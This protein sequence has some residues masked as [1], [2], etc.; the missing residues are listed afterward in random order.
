METIET[1]DY[2]SAY[3]LPNTMKQRRSFIRNLIDGYKFVLLMGFS[4]TGKT[5]FLE[6][7]EPPQ[8][9]WTQSKW[10]RDPIMD[11][12]FPNGKRIEKFHNYAQ[13]FEKNVIPKLLDQE[14]RQVVVENWARFPKSRAHFYHLADTYPTALFVFD[15]PDER[16]I[17]RCK[18][19]GKFDKEGKDLEMWLQQKLD[20]IT[21]PTFDEGW[22]D[23]VYIST[24]G[25]AGVEYFKERLV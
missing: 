5:T 19:S 24:F 23:I 13:Q 3:K 14:R 11:Q 4:G 8:P 22:D 2:T 17:E 15:G 6:S 20:A 1:R 10:N 16:I 21:W 7:C 25:E 18:K 9:N 12:L